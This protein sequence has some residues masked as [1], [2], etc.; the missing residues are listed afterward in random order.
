MLTDLINEDPEICSDLEG[1]R[2]LEN[3]YPVHC[4]I[5]HVPLDS[6]PA[7]TALSYTWGDASKTR[8]LVIEEDGEE[9][10]LRITENLDSAFR[11]LGLAGDFWIDAVCINQSDELEK[12]WQVQ[13]MWR[14]YNSAEC[15]AT[16]LGTAADDS[17]LLMDQ[18][19]KIDLID[20]AR[21]AKSTDEFSQVF[22]NWA[23]P[24]D[25]ISL[26]AFSALTKRA[27]WR[28][29][30]IQQE[31]H[32][33]SNGWL[34][35][36][37]KRV[38]ISFVYLVLLQLEKMQS[39]LRKRGLVLVRR[40]SFAAYLG[41]IK[42]D[43]DMVLTARAIKVHQ[44][45]AQ[46]L[47]ESLPMLLKRFYVY[48]KGL[49]ASDP[50]DFI[51]GLLN[52]S[53]DP[54]DLGITADYSKSKQKLFIEVATALIKRISLQLLLWRNTH[55]AK[56]TEPPLPSW[57]PDW[58]ARILIPLVGPLKASN[59]RFQASRD[60]ESEF[61]FVNSTNQHPTLAVTG[62]AMDFVRTVG[63]SVM[64][65]RVSDRTI[66]EHDQD[67]NYNLALRWLDD[68][69]RLSKHC[70]NIYG[71]K[72]GTKEAIWRTPIADTTLTPE[73]HQR[74]EKVLEEC[75]KFCRSGIMR[76][77]LKSHELE[78]KKFALAGRYW[79]LLVTRCSNRKLFAT[80]KGYLGL[81]PAASTPGDIIAVIFGL[82]APL[83]LRA[84]G[85]DEYQIVGE[86]YVHGIM[87][88]E[89]MN[90]SPSPQKFNLY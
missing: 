81:G 25:F 38:P 50:R 6:K 11:N 52:M 41:M 90:G 57:A 35:C 85:V 19:S 36:G 39:E 51:Y 60:S 29:V 64:E 48:G 26:P 59:L 71:G 22:K 54:A 86:A 63:D 42:N 46:K 75:Y 30:W 76:A 72:S 17:D 5:H 68:I 40:D 62:I 27:Y 7:Y 56:E 79:R 49:E 61:S 45:N 74:A 77:V 66:Y 65:I 10:E 83:V 2:Y 87:D 9:F 15:M 13:Q 58:S 43:D 82:N 28:R 47:V 53:T 14:I 24:E 80:E 73:G 33:S 20:R 32:A 70:G 69:E 37:R 44:T 31:L 21:D 84:S 78:Q 1:V 23:P 3:E 4:S 55:T 18:I 12:S 67:Q 88:G 89:A 16:W 34:H 8:P